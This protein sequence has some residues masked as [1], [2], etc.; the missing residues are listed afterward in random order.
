MLHRFSGSRSSGVDM[1]M[2]VYGMARRRQS[3]SLRCVS[4]ILFFL[5]KLR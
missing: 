4:I 1:G 3:A 5:F 2:Y